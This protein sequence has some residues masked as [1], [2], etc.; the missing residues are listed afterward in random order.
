MSIIGWME[1]QIE[2]DL[3][4]AILFSHKTDWSTDIRD[5]VNKHW[6]YANWNKPYTEGH[7]S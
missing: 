1:N 5:N 3:Q 4:N 7:R 6:K 2:A